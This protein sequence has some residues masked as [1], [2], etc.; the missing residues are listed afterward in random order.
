MTHR[1]RYSCVLCD[2]EEATSVVFKK[3]ERHIKNKHSLKLEDYWWKNVEKLPS[4]PTCKYEKCRKDKGFPAKVSFNRAAD[5]VNGGSAFRKFCS[6]GCRSAQ[7]LSDIVKKQLETP[8]GRNNRVIWAKSQPHS[9]NWR[10]GLKNAVVFRNSHEGRN[11]YEDIL[12][13]RMFICGLS[14]VFDYCG[15]FHGKKNEYRLDF[16]FPEVKLCIEVDGSYHENRVELDKERD[17]FLLRSGWST[18]R[19]SNDRVKYDVNSVVEEIIECIEILKLYS[20]AA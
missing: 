10:K 13:W 20:L 16:A 2:D 12:Y 17:R 19:V 9:E 8:E 7:A 15:F 1:N 4:H 11:P 18:F 5:F 14:P 6:V 3:L